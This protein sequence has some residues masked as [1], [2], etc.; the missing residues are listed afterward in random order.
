M[1]AFLQSQ[2]IVL[3]FVVV[4]LGYLLGRVQIG[5]M[6][7]GNSASMLIVGLTFSIIAQRANVALSLPPILSTLF[8]DLFIFAVGLKVGPQFFW[9]FDRDGRRYLLLAL[10]TASCSVALACAFARL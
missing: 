1:F 4:A 3:L 5:G 10:V 2:P 8:F 6:G 9:A 7:L